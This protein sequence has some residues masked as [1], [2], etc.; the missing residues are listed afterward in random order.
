MDFIDGA[1]LVW[2]PDSDLNT[3]KHL[4]KGL[5]VSDTNSIQNIQGKKNIGGVNMPQIKSY[6]NFSCSANE[7]KTYFGSPEVIGNV[8]IH[9]DPDCN[10]NLYKKIYSIIP[11]GDIQTSNSSN[12]EL[13]KAIIF[14]S[15]DT[16]KLIGC[17]NSY[18]VVG[19]NEIVIFY[20]YSKKILKSKIGRV[21][22]VYLSK[23]V[24]Y[25]NKN[26][27]DFVKYFG[28]NGKILIDFI[29]KKTVSEEHPILDG[30]LKGVSLLMAYTVGLFPK[31]IGW[32]C[33]A[34]GEAINEYLI[35]SE[36]I[37]NSESKNYWFPMIK[38][39]KLPSKEEMLKT[40]LIKNDEIDK[41]WKY[42]D[43]VMDKPVMKLL[44]PTIL[45]LMIDRAKASVNTFVNG[46]NDY[47][48]LSVEAI[49][50]I[51]LTEEMIKK[52]V[53]G[54]IAGI[55]GAIAG[56]VDFIAGLF[57]F[58]G[59]VGEAPFDFWSDFDL[60]KLI[61]LSQKIVGIT[62]QVFSSEMW[63]ALGKSFEK[64]WEDVNNIKLSEVNTDKVGYGLGFMTVFI[65][66]FFIP[67]TEVGKVANIQKATKFIP[68]GFLS[69]MSEQMGKTVIL[70]GKANSKALLL[71]DEVI[72]FLSKGFDE[73]KAFFDDLFKQVKD[74]LLKAKETSK[75]VANKIQKFN[76]KFV[77]SVLE[78][79]VFRSKSATIV[80]KSQDK[81]LAAL[82]NIED[83]IAQYAVEHAAIYYG[84]KIERVIGEASEVGFGLRQLL[85]MRNAIV[86]HNHPSGGSLSPADIKLFLKWG[87]KE[88][89]AKCPDGS[90][91]SLKN[92][93]LKLTQ[94]EISDFINK[95]SKVVD[96]EYK[97][98]KKITDPQ[99]LK[100]V[101]ADELIKRLQAK[102]GDKIDYVHYK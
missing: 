68:E 6:E 28:A 23:G 96:A 89:R 61:A 5:Q 77:N 35:P 42:V 99:I 55:F 26:N 19:D 31:I 102:F 92:N 36:N 48:K 62:G 54:T 83:E 82:K 15:N 27:K 30:I 85:K 59:M 75:E 51:P 60:D 52:S 14:V 84:G 100:N 65:A 25:M 7:L 90:V 72:A 40:L 37:W 39:G 21:A 74:W 9:E 22:R 2:N 11:S 97:I 38:D 17:Y 41:M 47:I 71:L 81:L 79:G 66:T 53:T 32:C 4:K 76:K 18:Q 43:T 63:V 24:D 93:G 34:V 91:F 87:L 57:I 8:S 67:F 88:L 56:A 50:A 69:K 80:A 70:A 20:D 45:N 98:G 94:K 46:T 1:P 101:E 44:S 13:A 73:L 49:Y 78:S 16:Q 10:C 58:V 86:T 95:T 29:D 33:S 64:F 12:K 3:F